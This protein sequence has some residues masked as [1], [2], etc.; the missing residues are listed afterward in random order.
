MRLYFYY[1]ENGQVVCY[2]ERQLEESGNH[3]LLSLDVSKQQLRDIKDAESVH[4]ESGKLVIKQS[5]EQIHR[6][7]VGNYIKKIKD[8]KATKADLEEALSYILEKVL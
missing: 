3:R 8:K 1:R 6:Q 5:D 2:S 4:I 7:K